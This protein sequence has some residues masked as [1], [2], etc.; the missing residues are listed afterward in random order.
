MW[1]KPCQQKIGKTE[2]IMGKNIEIHR[3]FFIVAD[4]SV[5]KM[6]EQKK[7]NYC[8]KNKNKNVII[9]SRAR[10]DPENDVTQANF[11][12]TSSELFNFF[13]ISKRISNVSATAS[14]RQRD[15]LV[16]VEERRIPP[17]KSIPP[18]SLHYTSHQPRILRQSR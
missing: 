11:G 6:N 4:Y 16:V 5:P 10:F 8:K 1:K 9:F 13:R 3:L 18:P 2:K 14:L 17:H 7:Q 12:R 15:R